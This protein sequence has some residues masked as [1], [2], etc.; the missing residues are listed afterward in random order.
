MTEAGMV[1]S[2]LY[3][4]HREPVRCM[5]YSKFLW[6]LNFVDFVICR[7]IQK[8]IWLTPLF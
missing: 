3:K 5:Y 2:H 4:G 6:E 7:K 1:L 8:T